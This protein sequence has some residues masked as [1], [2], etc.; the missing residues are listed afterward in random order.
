[1]L[2]AGAARISELQIPHRVKIGTLSSLSIFL[3]N[4]RNLT[5]KKRCPVFRLLR[6][7]MP[8]SEVE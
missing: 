3:F 7:P 2:S 4:F 6:F 1:M 8:I 5:P